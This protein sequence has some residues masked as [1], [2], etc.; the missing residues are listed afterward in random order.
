MLVKPYIT[1]FI[2]DDVVKPWMFTQ[3]FDLIHIRWLYGA[4]TERQF[5]LL[6]K[7]AYEYEQQ[8]FSI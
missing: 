5:D 7:Q 3:K 2:V 8:K 1:K 6:Y 4:L